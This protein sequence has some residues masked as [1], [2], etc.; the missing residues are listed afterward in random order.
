M[1]RG[2]CS[3]FAQLLSRRAVSGLTDMARM[4]GMGARK[5]FSLLSACTPSA[6]NDV[7]QVC[8]PA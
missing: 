6:S 8:E 2:E 1:P 3:Q 4:C 5:A 7:V